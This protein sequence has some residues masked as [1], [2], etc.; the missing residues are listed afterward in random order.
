MTAG[1]AKPRAFAVWWSQM[2]RWSVDSFRTIGWR[3]P[4]AALR[5][6]GDALT[7]RR[8]EVDPAQPKSEVPII[9]KISFGGAITV[10]DPD[11]RGGY[12]GRLFWAS[13]GELV[14]SKIRVKQGSLAIVPNSIE[15]LAVSAEYPVYRINATVADGHYLELVVR[16]EPFKRLLDGLSHGGSTKTR[17]PPDAFERLVVPLPPLPQQRAIVAAFDRARHRAAELRARAD[18]V[19][20]AAEADFLK[21]LGLTPPA[22]TAPPKV[23]AVRW[24]QA[25]RWSVMFNQLAL[26]SVDLDEGFHPVAALGKISLVSYG[27]QKSPANRPGEHTRPYLRV[28]NVQRG[29]LDLSEIKYINVPD[30][31]MESFRLLAGDLLVCE[32]NSPDLVGRPAIWRGEIENCVHQ[33]HVLRVRVKSDVAIPEFVLGYMQLPPARIYFRSRA[34]FTTNLASINS[35][36]LRGLQ[37][38][39][40]PL[41]EQARIVG[42]IKASYSKAADLRAQASNAEQSARAEAEAMI[43]GVKP[44]PSLTPAPRASSSAIRG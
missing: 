18:A 11:V 13:P 33:N 22:E 7:L 16:S 14:Y 37:I 44:P 29:A 23:F 5:P 4:R 25:E 36:D 17:I 10:T 12:K 43:L 19:D 20:A 34:K 15:S 24:S 1:A 32:G 27:L 38:P 2:E 41:D 40:P 30:K 39:L 6:L 42:M 28:A 31:E 21:A 35:N 26:R 9:E 3:W 8:D